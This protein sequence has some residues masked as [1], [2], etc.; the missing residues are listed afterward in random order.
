MTVRSASAFLNFARTFLKTLVRPMWSCGEVLTGVGRLFSDH[1]RKQTRARFWRKEIMQW[2]WTVGIS[3]RRLEERPRRRHN[4]LQW[5]PTSQQLTYSYFQFSSLSP[6]QPL[7]P[8]FLCCP[9]PRRII[10]F[11]PLSPWLYTH[12][13]W[14][15][16]LRRYPHQRLPP[17]SRMVVEGWCW[18]VSSTSASWTFARLSTAAQKSTSAIGRLIL[19]LYMAKVMLTSIKTI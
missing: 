2:R 17:P 9:H 10:P 6:H 19:S 18:V 12:R 1:C 8:R 7:L 4:H 3:L 5:C 15:D 14:G 16:L 11:P 13:Y